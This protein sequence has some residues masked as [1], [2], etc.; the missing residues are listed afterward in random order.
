MNRTPDIDALGIGRAM[1]RAKATPAR[2]VFKYPP[3]PKI[4]SVVGIT[5]LIAGTSAVAVLSML[6][7]M[8]DWPVGLFMIVCAIVLGL[9]VV[10]CWRD[11]RGKLG[12]R[13]ALDSETI[14]F[15][16]P[17]WR[18]LIHRPATR[19]LTIRYD[20]IDAIET[21]FEAYGGRFWE[22][23]QLSYVLRRKNGEMIFLFEDRA[24][25]TGWAP[26]VFEKITADFI[27]RSGVK[28][29]HLGMVEGRP[30]VLAAWGA[31][32]PDWSTPSVTPER[33]AQLWARAGATG[34]AALVLAST[35]P[36]AWLGGLL[37]SNA[38]RT[39]PKPFPPDLQSK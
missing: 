24:Q 3:G 7:I 6:V 34:R 5:V 19:H 13:I 4:L 2:R 21:R 28:L 15:D 27:A 32:A 16:L 39:P 11:L 31:H 26:R 35:V 20:D 33:Q 17:H 23:I 30:G 14:T 1:E 8:Q 22:N 25:G 10:Y 37:R 29:R 36:N 18:S 9:L 12:M 38:S